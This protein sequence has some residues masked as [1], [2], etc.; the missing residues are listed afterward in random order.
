MS[1]NLTNE[2]TAVR[3]HDM[4]VCLER[5]RAPEYETLV[6]LGLAVRMALHLRGV[7]PQ[8][9]ELLKQVAIYL[10][11]F[12]PAEVKPVLELLADAEMV[13]LSTEG[14]TIKTVT[15]DV[16][17]FSDL[18][19]NLGE[20][21]RSN[22]LAEAEELT[23]VM[24]QRLAGAPLMRDHLYDSGAEQKLVNRILDIGTDGQFIVRK[25]ARGRD[26]FLSPTYFAE[27]ASAYADLAAA[28]GSGRVKRILE[29]L[30]RAQGWPLA[31]IEK[32]KALAGV[33]LSNADVTILRAL[34]GD[35]F[36]PPPAIVTSHHGTNF[37][38][39]GPRPGTAR[40]PLNQKEIYE[41]AMALVAAVRQGQ[42]L[43][44][45]YSIRSPLRLLLS[46][47]ERGF[48]R[49]N[50]EAMEQYRQVCQMRLATLQPLGGEW[51]R[52]ELIQVPEN[53]SAIDM[54]IELL[55][56]TEIPARADEDII[57][58]LRQGQGYV[59]SL[60]GRKRLVE[61]PVVSMDMEAQ[62]EIDTFLLGGGR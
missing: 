53:E 16:P 25:R 58:A 1:G 29:L 24:L 8:P 5:S 27:N 46:L 17:F 61:N 33:S 49:A 36:V 32:D 19:S 56:N 20:V 11:N 28:S 50:T 48:L 22:R 14:K 31:L 47:K 57:L 38:L 41:R 42:L 9:Y 18:Y 15:P 2:E 44:G 12:G 59:E 34:A 62:E 13:H 30:R 45:R 10:W 37:F 35:G 3:A 43:P 7:P 6:L 39:F 55:S 54:A 60:L 26:I 21:A 4:V 51:A 23:V 40:L 52:L